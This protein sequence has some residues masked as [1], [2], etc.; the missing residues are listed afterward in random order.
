MVCCYTPSVY[1]VHTD[2]KCAAHSRPWLV[3]G[4]EGFC[5]FLP[6]KADDAGFE[7]AKSFALHGAHVIL[8][9]RN[10]ARASEAVSRILGEWDGTISAMLAFNFKICYD[11]GNLKQKGPGCRSRQKQRLVFASRSDGRIKS[12]GQDQGQWGRNVYPTYKKV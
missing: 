12:Q 1:K 5:D 7:T 11:F 6:S 4:S 9:C 3:K 10:M 2:L 8:A